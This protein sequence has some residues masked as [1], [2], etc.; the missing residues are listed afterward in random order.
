VSSVDQYISRALAADPID[1]PGRSPTSTSQTMA[2][3][4]QVTHV[5]LRRMVK[6]VLTAAEF[7]YTYDLQLPPRDDPSYVRPRP[8]DDEVESFAV[9]VRSASS[10][11]EIT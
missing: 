11:S 5:A 2:I 6:D 9:S 7:E 4:N 1:R 3:C 8:H 10:S